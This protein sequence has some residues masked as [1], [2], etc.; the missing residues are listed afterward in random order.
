[1]RVAVV[2]QKGGTGKTTIAFHL[3]L[4]LSR[5]RRV[6]LV[7]VDP[8]GNLTSC[9]TDQ[10][11]LDYRHHVLRAFE[12]EVMEPIE[13]GDI[14]L[15]GSNDK[16]SRVEANVD[17]ES[18][19]KLSSALDRLGG[20]DLAI[21]DSPPTLGV[22]TINAI[23]A[24][25]AVLIPVD[26]SFFSLEGIADLLQLIS[27]LNRRT[28]HRCE[29]LG[30]VL[31]N[32]DRRTRLAREIESHLRETYGEKVFKTVISPSVRVREAVGLGKPVFLYAPSSK[33]AREMEDLIDEFEERISHEGKAQDT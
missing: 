9:F 25:D 1:M 7:D 29:V 24:A 19:F 6:L 5:G 33:S 12:E 32:F 28:A 20:F 18:F 15:V 11:S 31:N 22:L 26:L 21:I 8:Q 16:L 13:A 4:G 17:F 23:L 27:K 14:L 2:N 30:F 10:K 3:G